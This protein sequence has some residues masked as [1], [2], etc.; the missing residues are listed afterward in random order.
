MPSNEL[1]NDRNRRPRRCYGDVSWTRVLNN[2]TQYGLISSQVNDSRNN[3]KRLI[4][5]YMES[6]SR[7][8]D[9]A[10][11]LKYVNRSDEK[12]IF[13][14]WVK[15]HFQLVNKSFLSIVLFFFFCFL[16]LSWIKKKKLKIVLP[17]ALFL[18][19]PGKRSSPSVT[20]VNWKITKKK[21]NTKMCIFAD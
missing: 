7:K 15:G 12:N 10:K 8:L 6:W 3:Y 17:T 21:K 9:G 4:D 20:K 1:R 14:E 2:M 11:T 5:N 19:P 18:F 13:F 16:I